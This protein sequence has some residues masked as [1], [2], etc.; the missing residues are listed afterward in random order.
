M[1]TRSPHPLTR[2]SSGTLPLPFRSPLRRCRTRVGSGTLAPSTPERPTRET[3]YLVSVR[4]EG[5][6]PRREG[7]RPPVREVGLTPD[8]L[9]RVPEGSPGQDGTKGRRFSFRVTLTNSLSFGLSRSGL[10]SP[11]SLRGLPSEPGS[12]SPLRG[13]VATGTVFRTHTSLPPRWD[14][15]ERTFSDCDPNTGLK[16]SEDPSDRLCSGPNRRPQPVQEGPSRTTLHDNDNPTGEG[17]SRPW[18]EGRNGR[19]REITRG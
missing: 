19:Q 8:P 11:S 18:T 3:G 10:H 6:L 1:S 16:P 12:V 5:S 7:P 4:R 9:R 17:P 2:L 15:R 14:G 13:R